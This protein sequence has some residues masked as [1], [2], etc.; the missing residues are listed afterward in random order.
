MLENK[1]LKISKG[2]AGMATK[3]NSRAH[4]FE[5]WREGNP[6]NMLHLKNERR[7][8]IDR[9]VANYFIHNTAT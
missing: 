9:G 2:G 1:C 5:Q 8:I 7:M 3:K 4:R 6:V